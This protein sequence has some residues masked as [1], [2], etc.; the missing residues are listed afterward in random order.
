[1]IA[2]PPSL[3]KEAR[4]NF[5]TGLTPWFV[6][7]SVNVQSMT[8]RD[9]T[10]KGDTMINQINIV[11]LI[12]SIRN[13]SEGQETVYQ[14][15]WF[16]DD[17]LGLTLVSINGNLT[18]RATN[19]SQQTVDLDMSTMCV[20]V[21]QAMEEQRSNAVRFLDPEQAWDEI[22]KMHTVPQMVQAFSNEYLSGD[23][24]AVQNVDT[25]LRVSPY[26]PSPQ[27]STDAFMVS[28]D[29]SNQET[30]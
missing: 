25:V 12:G 4:L 24:Q 6:R 13:L 30:S 18:V 29:F 16:G 2:T 7:G 19:L 26:S 3:I 10:H 1:M 23:K 11:R 20:A 28:I 9:Q 22:S 5:K 8:G 17:E 21:S 27:E 15:G 14:T